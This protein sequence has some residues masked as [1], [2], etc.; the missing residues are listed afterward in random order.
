VRR[1]RSRPSSAYLLFAGSRV[2]SVR[3]EPVL[4]AA[5]SPAAGEE[6]FAPAGSIF[7]AGVLAFAAAVPVVAFSPFG[8][9]AASNDETGATARASA[10]A[11]AHILFSI[12]LPPLCRTL[13][14]R[15]GFNAKGRGSVA[16]TFDASR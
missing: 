9:P 13:A 10:K 14:R 6:G 2:V 1:A 3:V 7:A 16:I 12:T 4:D 15:Q 5:G 11:R 8:L